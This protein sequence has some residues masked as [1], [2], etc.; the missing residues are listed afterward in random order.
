M[1]SARDDDLPESPIPR[2]VVIEHVKKVSRLAD[3]VEIILRYGGGHI[4]KTRDPPDTIITI[5]GDLVGLPKLKAVVTGLGYKDRT[6]YI[7]PLE[8]GIDPGV[9]DCKKLLE[10]K[11]TSS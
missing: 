1:A 6:H 9:N 5:T 4:I 2:E 10:Q 11:G 8:L 3:L 7:S